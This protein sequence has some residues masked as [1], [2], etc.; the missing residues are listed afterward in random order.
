MRLQSDS[1][2]SFDSDFVLSRD[3]DMSFRS[4]INLRPRLENQRPALVGD[5]IDLV[6]GSDSS[7]DDSQATIPW[8]GDITDGQP[9][10]WNA[11]GGDAMDVEG[12]P[13]GDDDGSDDGIVYNQRV[14]EPPVGGVDDAVL[15]LREAIRSDAVAQ[16]DARA[17]ERER[18]AVAAERERARVEKDEALAAEREKL[19]TV[20]QERND[21]QRKV[22]DMTVEYTRELRRQQKRFSELQDVRALVSEEWQE[23]SHM[24]EESK[25]EREALEQAMLEATKEFLKNSFFN[26]IK[27]RAA[28]IFKTRKQQQRTKTQK[29]AAA[30]V[31]IK[32]LSSVEK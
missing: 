28:E 16:A 7:D 9:T 14:L 18:A 11:A 30:Y 19:I 20:I 29:M 8:E 31:G 13:A 4:P 10:P 23:M 5:I 12:Q 27:K 17:E 15:R 24:L 32:N 26:S 1:S 21:L 2:A 3:T 25:M 22:H 6:S